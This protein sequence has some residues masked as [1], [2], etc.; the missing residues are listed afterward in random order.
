MGRL[1][2]EKLSEEH[3]EALQL[4]W[5]DE[6]VIKYTNVKKP[7]TLEEIKARIERFL[8]FDIYCMFDQEEFIG[9]LGCPAI[10]REKGEYGVFYQLKKAAWGKG[11]GKEAATWL[12]ESMR[13]QYGEVIFYADVVTLNVASEKIL[14]HLGFTLVTKEQDAFERGGKKMTVHHYILK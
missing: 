6:E 11:Y 5:S 8:P 3:S 10:S 12:I 14:K 13:K 4:I 9:I 1:T 7:C 2:Y